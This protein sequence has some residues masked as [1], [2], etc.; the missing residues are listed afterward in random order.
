MNLVK[1]RH[2]F[3]MFLSYRYNYSLFFVFII[4]CMTMTIMVVIVIFLSNRDPDYGKPVD[5][6]AIGCIM[7]ELTDGQPMFPGESELDQL[8][9]LL[10]LDY[11][12]STFANKSVYAIWVV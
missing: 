1:T 11:D 7:G 2:I 3:L 4:I 5:I 10:G 12:L 6:W 9:V 8:Y